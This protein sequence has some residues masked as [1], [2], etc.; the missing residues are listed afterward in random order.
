M[1]YLAIF[2][3]A[4]ISILSSSCDESESIESE[5]TN[6]WAEHHQL[7][8]DST[9]TANKLVGTWKLTYRY[10]CPESSTPGETRNVENEN[11]RLSITSDKIYVFIDGELTQESDWSLKTQDVELFGVD[12]EPFVANTFGRILF[13]DNKVLFNGS[14]IDG[15]DNYFVKLIEN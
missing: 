2:T 9:S 4:T 5:L 3:I 12:A 6:F 10:C 1:K 14:Y 15:A 11:Y 8:W 7:E 13:A